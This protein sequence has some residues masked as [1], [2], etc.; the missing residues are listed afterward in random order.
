[1]RLRLEKYTSPLASLLIVTDDEGALRALD[2]ADYEQRMHRLLRAHYAEY[3]LES[4]ASPICITAS[5]DAYF[6]G[7]LDALHA[8]QVATGG[9]TFQRRVWQALRAIPAGSTTSYGQIAATIDCPN[10]S[11]AVGAANGSNPVAIV[12]PCHRVIGANGGLTGYGGGLPRKRWLL[13]HER[14]HSSAN[15]DFSATVQTNLIAGLTI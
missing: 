8:I 2:F 13:E 15:A 7:D 12:V 3:E 5:L 9:T 10:A 11:R 14:K 4:G 1:M 6:T